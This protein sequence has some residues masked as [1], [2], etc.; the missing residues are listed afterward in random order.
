MTSERADG[1]PVP[2]AEPAGDVDDRYR[3]DRED[4]VLFE[5]PPSRSESIEG[6][7]VWTVPARAVAEGS[8]M[9]AYFHSRSE[10][11]EDWARDRALSIRRTL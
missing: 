10:E 4:E 5:L 11:D 2:I 3:V 1:S 7:N 9:P 6:E 8:V